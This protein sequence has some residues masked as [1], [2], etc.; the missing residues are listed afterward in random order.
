MKVTVPY[1][2]TPRDYQFRVL[3]ALEEGYKRA[4]LVWHR[5][6]GKDKTALN[7]VVKKAFERVGNYYYYLPTAA[8]G[9]K[10]VWQGKDRDG[11]PFL[12]HVP[13]ELRSRT[14]EDEMR[15]E[16]INGSAIQ[17]IGTDK[18]DVVG[19]NPVGCIFSEYSLQDPAAWN[20]IRPILAENDGW[21]IFL[22]CVSPETLVISR[23]GLVRMGDLGKDR[24]LGFSPLNK[25]I[26][27]L[28]GFHNAS[29]F[30][31]SEKKPV[32]KIK[33]RMG[34][35]VT[36]TPNHPLYDGN[37][38]R[39]ACTWKVGDKIPI[40]RGQQVFGDHIPEAS[41]KCSHK[42]QKTFKVDRRTAYILGLWLAEGSYNQYNTTIT[43]KY[44]R[45]L[46][47][48]L[49]NYGFKAYDDVHYVLSSKRF[50]A[51]IKW[52]GFETGCHNK[53]IPSKIL[54]LP[55]EHLVDFIR[56]YF[57]GDGCATK[58]GGI[59][60]DSVSSRLI[61][62][63]QI[64]LLN[65]GIVSRISSYT[66]EPTKKVKTRSLVN[67]L[68]IAGY[69]AHL[70]YQQIGFTLQR[71]QTRQEFLSKSQKEFYG[72]IVEWPSKSFRDVYIKG[73]NMTDLKRH[74]FVSYK[75]LKRA[76]SKKEDPIVK[77]I[78]D[79]CFYYDNIES[80]ECDE[81]EVM[82][83]VIPETRSFF[84]NGFISHNTPR[85][86]QHG[87]TLFQMAK[88]NP[89]WYCEL[90]TADDTNAITPEAIE[91]ERASGMSEE[92]IQQEFFAS[93]DY[94]MEGSYYTK[95]LARARQEGRITRLPIQDISVHTAW[96][97]GYRD[98]TAI[99]FFQFV[100]KEIWVIDYYENSGEELAHYAKVLQEKG[101]IYGEHWAPH[102]IEK[103]E[104]GTGASLRER[105]K[106][107]GLEFNV[108]ENWS[109]TGIGLAEGIE[110][111]RSLF[112][113]FWFHEE[114][115]KRGLDALS[116]YKKKW[117]PLWA[118]FSDQPAKNWARDGADAFRILSLAVLKETRRG[119][120]TETEAQNLYEA[121][122]P[123]AI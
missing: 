78:L 65:F 99:W 123:P 76:Y 115:T 16:L 102:D 39:K 100:G 79:N 69:N 12:G 21:A 96:D 13:Q 8:L 61:K 49:V 87:Y 86:R 111:V 93:F 46:H 18:T 24:D 60:C 58:R 44:D 53:K 97:I 85:G 22:Y 57:D 82:D 90:L 35:S 11:F 98:A 43:T 28:G 84:S 70:F 81:S 40:Q 5:R 4:V 77:Q 10:I 3:K 72:D 66:V 50:V 75:I 2:F 51:F 14:R 83:F 112:P 7:I 34:F 122:A 80:V 30:Y 95:Q 45:D 47:N 56:G 119:R 29:L 101:Y 117:D 31:K 108:I 91:E 118:T 23:S 106:D 74:G 33:T 17:V 104:L 89:S 19:P 15:I 38:W 103:H 105:A 54:G 9:R 32:L 121:Y 59:H 27:G 63:L 107:L 52:L 67:R 6:A 26:Y 92:L 68:E 55:K 42:N 114:N 88:Y 120:M 36:C 109:R 94:G 37:E 110:V 116:E 73:L 25:D 41:F 64:V 20:Y 1:N 62:D 48:R 113:R 71:K